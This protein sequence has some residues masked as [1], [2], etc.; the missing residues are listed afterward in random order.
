MKKWKQTTTLLRILIPNRLADYLNQM[1][2]KENVVGC[3]W[4]EC[5][6]FSCTKHTF[7]FSY[8]SFF[9]N[10]TA[11]IFRNNVCMPSY[12][13]NVQKT[14]LFFW[15]STHPRHKHNVYMIVMRFRLRKGNNNKTQEPKLNIKCVHVVVNKP[16]RKI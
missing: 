12:F 13:C 15:R 1:E 2:N 8:L 9:P 3:E 6:A 14:T 10:Q 7:L 4:K 5:I 16:L 11:T